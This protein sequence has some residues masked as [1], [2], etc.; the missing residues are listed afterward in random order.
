MAVDA[1]VTLVQIL[2][3]ALLGG[4]VLGVVGTIVGFFGGILGL[5]AGFFGPILIGIIIAVLIGLAVFAIKGGLF[6][7]VGMPLI[8]GLL[9]LFGA[10][11][12]G[13]GALLIPGI[14]ILI[15]GSAL[16]IFVV[17]AIFLGFFGLIVGI[18]MGPILGIVGFILGPIVGGF[19][20]LIGGGIIAGV[21]LGILTQA[22]FLPLLLFFGGFGLVLGLSFYYSFG[23]V[24]GSTNDYLTPMSKA[25]LSTFEKYSNLESD[26]LIS[27]IDVVLK[28][29]L[30]NL[31]SVM[32]R[33]SYNTLKTLEIIVDTTDFKDADSINHATEEVI[34]LLPAMVK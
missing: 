20:G 34:N 10:F 5:L 6:L 31:K 7:V 22:V 3:G 8:N 28:D 32:G 18:G 1:G 27:Q 26:A 15:A 11:L 13:L 17:A 4:A 24:M 16:I 25:V 30:H 9:G 21:G 14:L 33:K 29:L 12:G 19:G 23:P 2:I